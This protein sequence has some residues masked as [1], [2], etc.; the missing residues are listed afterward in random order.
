MRGGGIDHMLAAPGASVLVVAPHPDDEAIGAGVLIQRAVQLGARVMIVF[1]TDGDNNPW[2]QRAMERRI[3]IGAVDRER[4][5]TRRRSEALASAAEL[6][7]AA[8]AVRNLGLPDLGV[9]ERL[10]NHT[11]TVL[12]AFERVLVDASPTLVV[13]PS[14][15]D[16]HPDHSGAYVLASIALARLG[17]RAQ[18]ASYV[19]HGTPDESGA[20]CTASPEMLACKE[21]ALRAHRSQLVLSERRMLAYARRPERFSL[22]RADNSSAGDSSSGTVGA[23]EAAGSGNEV[24]PHA[25]FRLPWQVSHITAACCAVIVVTRNGASRVSITSEQSRSVETTRLRAVR[26]EGGRL[27]LHIPGGLP[28]DSSVFVKLMYRGRSPWIYDR[29]GWT[30]LGYQ[31]QASS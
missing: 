25:Y 12:S 4:W 30:M 18:R 11:D 31:L 7:V 6:G 26:D 8:S 16:S 22:G 14:L 5:A 28:I 17:S 1:I 23:G 15:A 9:T 29:W 21:R 13:L 20:E 10:V 27:L 3:G 24:H 2:P 19:I